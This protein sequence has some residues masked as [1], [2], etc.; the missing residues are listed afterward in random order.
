LTIELNFGNFLKIV[1]TLGFGKIIEG[2]IT[3]TRGTLQKGLASH[4]FCGNAEE[5][6]DDKIPRGKG[7]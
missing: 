4:Q 6:R 7:A 2:N 5:G 1:I 3:D